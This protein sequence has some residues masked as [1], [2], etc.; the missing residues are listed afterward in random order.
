MKNLKAGDVVMV[1]FPYGDGRPV[2]KEHPVL[3]L[4][5]DEHVMYVAYGSSKKL[6]AAS[7]SGTAVVITDPEDVAAT[8]LDLPT[9]F[10]IDKRARLPRSKCGRH[11]NAIP[12][13]KYQQLY[14]AAVRVG[15]LTR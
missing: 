2:D 4:E 12:P 6:A 8:G 9:A 14:R 5:C 13:H 15:L 1:E 7:E 11:L 10:H 3:V